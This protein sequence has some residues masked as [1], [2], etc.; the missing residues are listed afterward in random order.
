MARPKYIE[1]RVLLELIKKYFYEECNANIKK[2]KA[3]EIIKYINRH[4]YPDYPATTLRR[5]PAAMEYIEEL[6][7]A[8]N[9]DDY[10]TIESYR[11]I[12]AVLIVQKAGFEKAKVLP[13]YIQNTWMSTTP[14]I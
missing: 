14:K 2:L 4:G 10:I 1:D 8:I 11:T 12:D 6:K 7:K 3:S 5:T 9:D 13:N